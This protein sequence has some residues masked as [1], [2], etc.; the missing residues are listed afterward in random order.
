MTSFRVPWGAWYGDKSFELSVPDDWSM[1]VAQPPN[2][3]ALSQD[4]LAARFSMPLGSPPLRDLARGR[5]SA[6]IVIDDL[7]RPTPTA[8]LLPMVLKELQAGGISRENVTVLLGQG[9]HRPLTRTDLLKKIGPLVDELSVVCHNPYENLV[10]IGSTSFGTPVWLSRWYVE[11]DLRVT[12]GCVEPHPAYG[13]SGGCKLVFPGLAG[14]DSI[15]ANHR[16]NHLSGGPLVLEGN[17]KRVDAE[18]AVRMVGLDCIV[19]AVVTGPRQVA[20]LFVG[21]FVTAHRAATRL[22]ERVFATPIAGPADIVVFNAYPKDT[23]LIQISN[24]VNAA[25][26]TKAWI[27]HENSIVVI[28]CAASEGVGYHALYLRGGRMAVRRPLPVLEG[29]RVFVF[30]PHG[31]ANELPDIFPPETEL[32]HD[33]GQIVCRIKGLCH[34]T[35]SVL[36]LPEGSL[37][38]PVPA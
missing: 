31:R 9:G 10:F 38:I 7:S 35:P 5:R 14:I 29:R 23:E 17:E 27:M 19:N 1:T 28:T 22:A 25:A 24:A 30:T 2:V 13:F 18:E 37:Q 34:S 6:A 26:T 12:I 33:W 20:G 16:P 11:S 15:Y 3:P 21:D 36:V 8:V 32:H 4:E